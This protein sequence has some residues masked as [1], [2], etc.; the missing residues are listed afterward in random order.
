[1][2]IC[3][4]LHIK[5]KV[6]TGLQLALLGSADYTS[7]FCLSNARRLYPSRRSWLLWHYHEVQNGCEWNQV[8]ETWVLGTK[9]RSSVKALR[10]LT[11]ELSFQDPCSTF[12][13]FFR[14]YASLLFNLFYTS[15]HLSKMQF[16]FMLFDILLCVF[17]RKI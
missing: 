13:P 3:Q 14:F 4:L 16:L 5:F 15:V 2:P 11:A 17:H 8:L 10:T 7:S 1:M 6:D 9:H 12:N